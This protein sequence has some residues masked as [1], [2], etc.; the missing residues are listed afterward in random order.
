VSIAY[1][2]IYRKLEESNAV[3]ESYRTALA[4]CYI[5]LSALVDSRCSDLPPE[6]R[7]RLEKIRDETLASLGG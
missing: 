6:L 4:N 3:R 1:E 7:E 5:K 2:Q